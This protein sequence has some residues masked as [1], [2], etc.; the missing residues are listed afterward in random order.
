MRASCGGYTGAT[1]P[2][3]VGSKR[4]DVRKFVLGLVAAIAFV[5]PVELVRIFVLRQLVRTVA[6]RLVARKPALAQPLLLPVDDEL[7]GFHARALDDPWHRGLR[8]GSR[9]G[10]QQDSRV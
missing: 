4:P 6:E 2:N 10:E 8:R 9:T 3:A 5:V 7:R 1:A